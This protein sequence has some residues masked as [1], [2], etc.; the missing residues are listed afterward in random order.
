[1]KFSPSAGLT[2]IPVTGLLNVEHDGSCICALPSVHTRRKVIGVNRWDSRSSILGMWA[3]R[4]MFT[5][6]CL[7]MTFIQI[8]WLLEVFH[9]VS[10]CSCLTL[11]ILGVP[12]H[13]LS[14]GSNVW[15]VKLSKMWVKLSLDHRFLQGRKIKMI[16]FPWSK[17]GSMY[18]YIL[19]YPT[20]IM[21]VEQLSPLPFLSYICTWP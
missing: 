3:T 12:S 1:M 11:L 7:I 10:S 17:V 9:Y 4:C 20:S 16:K 19:V 8:L 14:T 13:T 15:W 18:D 5:G 21:R 6:L 2:V